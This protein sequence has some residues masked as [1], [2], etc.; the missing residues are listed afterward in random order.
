MTR[1]VRRIYRGDRDIFVIRFGVHPRPEGWTVYEAW[2]RTDGICGAHST[3]QSREGFGLPESGW[4]GRIGTRRVES[5]L[6]AWSDERYK[7]VTGEYAA[8]YAEA[9]DCI[10]EAFPEAIHGEQRMG[11]IDVFA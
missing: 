3:I 6:P 2:E 1:Q 9:Y 8:Q 11:G 10:L 5:D 4:M 7:A